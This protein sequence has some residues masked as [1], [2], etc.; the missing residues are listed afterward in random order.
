MSSPASRPA[1][2]RRQGRPPVVADARER[3]LLEASKLFAQSG[4]E[5]SSIGELAAAIGVSK[6]AIYHYFATKQDIYDAIILQAL[7]GL[8]DAVVPAVDAQPAP[9]DKLRVFMTAHAAYLEHNYWSFVAMLVG[10]SGMSPS[11][12]DDASRLR[13]AYERLL[14]QIL[15]QGAR[16]GVFRPGQIVT[17]GR[18]VLS[19]LNWMARWFKPGHGS[20]AEQ[21][22]L[23]YFELLSA[24]LCVRPAATS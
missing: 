6:P 20:T 13:D 3:I 21:I 17:S 12:R 18:A 8:T 7:Q 5:S 15:E 22:A 14:R 16:E 4:Y 1:P 10:F 11:Y 9:L 24:G 2:R 19:L 23:D